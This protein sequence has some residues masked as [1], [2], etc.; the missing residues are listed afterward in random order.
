MQVQ[1]FLKAAAIGIVTASKARLT[2]FRFLFAAVSRAKAALFR[3]GCGRSRPS[4]IGV[5]RTVCKDNGS[6]G[7]P[8][9]SVASRYRIRDV[10]L[11][12]EEREHG[13]SVQSVR[14]VNL[15]CALVVGG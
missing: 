5:H 14:G 6:R 11:S 10:A 13:R 9:F 2:I 7:T 3:A 4:S 1:L 12:V 15:I 8:T